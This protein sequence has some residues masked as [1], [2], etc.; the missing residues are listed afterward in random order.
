L[1]F[2]VPN[3]VEFVKDPQ[4]LGLSISPAQETCLR[5]IYGLSM[6]S[7]QAEIFR[8]CTQRQ[9]PPTRESPEVTVIS[10]ARSGKDSRIGVPVLIYEAVYGG[11]DRNLALG[12]KAIAALVAQDQRATAIA[13]GYARDYL[14]RSPILSQMIDEVRA[15][16]V[17]LTNR[18]RIACFPS[19]L[20]SLRGWS[21]PVGVMDEL[22][23]FRLEGAAD[24]DVEIQA[25]LRRGMIAFARTKLIKI[26][27]PYM[28]SGVLHDDFARFG[29]DNPDLLVWRSTS[30]LMNPTLTA[31]RLETQRRL[32]PRRYAREY[33]AEW[34]DDVSAFLPREW[35]A[36]AV[37]TGRY[38]IT[39]Q[40]GRTTVMAIDPSGG[41]LDAFT[42]SICMAEGDGENRR[43]VQL[44]MRGYA[45]VG[46][47]SPD[48]QG[49]VR[50][51]AL[52]AREYGCKLVVGD[53]YAA[54]WVK[55]AYEQAGIH[56]RHSDFDRSQA[57]LNV[58][59]LF[60][61]NRIELLDHPKLIRELELLERTP[62]PG[63]KDQVTHPRSGHDDYSNALAL[64]AC[65]ATVAEPKMA[66]AVIR[67]SGLTPGRSHPEWQDRIWGC[68]GSSE[69]QP[70]EAL[71]QR[72]REK[73]LQ[74]EREHAAS[75]ADQNR[76]RALMGL[77]PQE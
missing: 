67:S 53:R 41:G 28:R 40:R 29:E 38:E 13:F 10:G 1:G 74:S 37:V 65:Y 72:H 5:A 61:Q 26:S 30:A 35:I 60:A 77:P 9:E 70:S 16:E 50:E 71:Q 23:F 32:D 48:L 8:L 18:V 57:Y 22:A 49:L 45:R 47:T 19:T 75:R 24:S 17:D 15:T 36:S 27:T 76:R 7:E 3:I 73:A 14:Q 20:R 59:P 62:R 52:Q 64:A 56:Y 2:T 21:I 39:P 12:E 55:Q 33:E 46:T 4:L 68:S 66:L 31:E 69:E 42:W 6:S 11:H 43:V 63:G 25:S 51:S 54:G 58:E 44:V 34:S